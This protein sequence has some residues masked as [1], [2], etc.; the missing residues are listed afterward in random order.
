MSIIKEYVKI[1]LKKTFTYKINKYLIFF[2]VFFDFLGLLLFWATLYHMDAV[3]ANWTRVEL[4]CLVG[5]NTLN[6]SVGSLLI[7]FRDIDYKIT[8]GA[9][10]SYFMKPQHPLFTMIFERANFFIVILFFVLGMIVV[11]AS[12]IYMNANILQIVFA[13][14]MSLVATMSINILYA[15]ISLF[16]F[17]FGRTTYI[18]DTIFVAKGLSNYPMDLFPQIVYKFCTYIIPL[19][20]ISTFPVKILSDANNMKTMLE[21]SLINVLLMLAF[22]AIFVLIWKKMIK[23][24]ESTGV[25]R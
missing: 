15:I 5:F 13:V 8:D 4:V 17:K 20:F 24:Y 7:A 23:L 18:R 9:F 11:C 22:M 25:S 3:I 19:A 21:Y 10:D 6:N 1:S 14:F 12:S 2:E 16:S